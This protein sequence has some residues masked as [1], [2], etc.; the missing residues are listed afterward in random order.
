MN[1]TVAK[2]SKLGSQPFPARAEIVRFI[3]ESPGPVGK[4]EIARAFKLDS[5]QKMKLKGI[6]RELE[7]DGSVQ[8]GKGKSL[9]EPGTLPNVSVIDLTGLDD[10][11]DVIGRPVIW[12]H[13]TPVPVIRMVR[14]RTK[15]AVGPGDK[16]LARMTLKGP[17]RS[18]GSSLYE[19]RVIK[20]L[21]QRAREVIGIFE[22]SSE[23]G[24]IIPS[25]RKAKSEL[26]VTKGDTLDA[27]AGEVVRARVNA[28]K[29]YGLPSATVIERF[30]GEGG[31]KSVSLLAIAEADIPVAFSE[32]ALAAASKATAAPLG[33]REDLRTIPLVTI[34]GADARDFDDAVFAEAD[35]DPRNPDGFHLI[36]AI[37]DVSWY[38]QPGQP[39]DSDA[40]ERGNSVY[41]P[42]RVVPM[43]PE[44]LSNGWCSLVPLEDRPTFAV[45]LWINGDGTL[46]RHKFARAAIR[47]AARLTYIQVQT[48]MD[49]KPDDTTAPL[50]DAAIRPLYAAYGALLRGRRARGVLELEMPE[51]TAIIGPEGSVTGV[52]VRER[53]DSHKL[54]EEFMILANVA[55][56]TELEKRQV[57]GLYRIHDRP[58][59]EKLSALRDFLSSMDM[60]LA[61]GNIRPR[62]FNAIIQ[63][64]SETPHA[65]MVNEIILRSQAQAVYAPGNIGHFGLALRTYAHFTSPIRRYSDLVVHR[66]LIET[67]KLGDDGSVLEPDD[68]VRMGEHLSVTERRASGAERSAMDR[69][70]S[71]FLADRIGG[72]FDA[73]I[74]GATRAGLFVTLDETGA[75]GLI[76]MSRLPRDFYDVDA[77]RHRLVGRD[78]GQ[79][80][81]VGQDVEVR[82]VEAAPVS[83]GL[84]FE[85]MGSG[86]SAAQR[87]HGNNAARIKK[88]KKSHKKPSKTQKKLRQTKR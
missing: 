7:A 14:D 23:G 20:R 87:P 79:A 59:E 58:S 75:D 63:K 10:M 16:V 70:M 38:V 67:L 32:D 36:V 60:H 12:D 84:I 47:S 25:D 49:G 5:V 88:H 85:I 1:G 74:N 46:L 3:L 50:M 66:A 54:I 51:R 52:E 8:K 30:G 77:A 73:H 39:L 34:D 29:S 6:L 40:K 28:G 78:S 35:S 55:A 21:A 42:D 43:L 61:A 27:Q 82:L 57:G 45:H 37:A 69:F 9:A 19:G 71:L 17:K 80:F 4:R 44:A 72:I 56:G 22:G 41:F 65:R 83:G 53:V 26:K 15:A 31:A 13:D 24:R 86:E 2:P 11:G 68:L 76:P 62:Q 64:A 48:A 81:Q 18:D 33:G